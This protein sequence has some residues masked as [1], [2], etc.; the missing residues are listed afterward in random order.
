VNPLERKGDT[1]EI[2]DFL[3]EVKFHSF[4]SICLL[5]VGL[6]RNYQRLEAPVT[7]H[8]NAARDIGL[9]I[10]RDAVIVD[11]GLYVYVCIEYLLIPEAFK[12]LLSCVAVQ[13]ADAPAQIA[14]IYYKG[15]QS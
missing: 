10:H 1:D 5:E 8:R 15:L 14:E 11:P 7:K 3:A 2:V 4:R 9:N 13:R 6:D 12:E